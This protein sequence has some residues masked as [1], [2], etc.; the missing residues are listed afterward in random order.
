MFSTL[1]QFDCDALCASWLDAPRFEGDSKRDLKV[2]AWLKLMEDGLALR[3]VPKRYWHA[4][5]QRYMGKHACDRLYE[6]KKVMMNLSRGVFIWD[7]KKFVVAMK[8]MNWEI[9]SKRTLP[10]RVDMIPGLWWVVPK[11]KAKEAEAI[12]PSNLNTPFLRRTLRQKSDTPV[13]SAKSKTSDVPK[14]VPHAAQKPKT[15]PSHSKSAS[16]PA[17]SAKTERGKPWTLLHMRK[18][19]DP[20]QARVAN[21]PEWLLTA[22]QSLDAISTEYPKTISVL[23][24][25]LITVGSVPSLP[26]V[27]G[28]AL[29]S[30]TAHA[31]G[32]AAV[33][34]GG[35]L[36][37]QKHEVVSAA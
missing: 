17:A 26:V 5:A 36:T 27:A 4:V 24:A 20:A 19:D 3:K 35:W 31:I 2:E 12:L 18:P 10:F 23:A 32:G 9:D 7:W 37:S 21:A 1:K 16:F 29:A 8:N 34:L 11:E 30:G 14:V 15:R 22:C 28:T 6:V 13:V 25:V 33:G